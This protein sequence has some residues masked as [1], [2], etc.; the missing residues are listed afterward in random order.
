MSNIL[1][2][3]NDSPKDIALKFSQGSK[4]AMLLC[5]RL[6]NEGGQIDTDAVMGPLATFMTL[7]SAGLRGK[8]MYRLYHKVCNDDLR[9]FI[10]A[11]RAVQ[12]GVINKQVLLLSAKAER[13]ESRHMTFEVVQSKVIRRLPS[14]GS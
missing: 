9:L 1:I 10:I 13:W 2:S 5:I 6:F 4:K 11:V 3:L 8:P 7:D 14:L 12:L